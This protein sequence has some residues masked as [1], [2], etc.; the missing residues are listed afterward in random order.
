[1]KRGFFFVT[2]KRANVGFPRTIKCQLDVLFDKLDP[3]KN[4]QEIGLSSGWEVFWI[5]IYETDLWDFYFYFPCQLEVFLMVSKIASKSDEYKIIENF[6]EYRIVQNFPW[7]Q[8]CSEFPL[9]TK[10]FRISPEYKIVENYDETIN[11]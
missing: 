10:L 4:W 9:N 6:L 7:I 5:L 8:N 11:K 2:D 3:G 1:M